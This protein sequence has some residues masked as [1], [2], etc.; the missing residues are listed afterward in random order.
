MDQWTN[1]AGMPPDEAKRYVLAHITD[2]NLLKKQIDEAKAEAATW[3]SRAA[4]A[5]AKGMAELQSQ[6]Q[7][8]LESA[9]AKIQSL[10]AEAA[11]LASDIARMKEQ[12]PGLEARV[13]SVDPDVL[14]AGLQM[15]TGEMDDPGK[16]R[17]ESDVK[18]VQADDALAALKARLGLRPDEGDAPADDVGAAGGPLAGEGPTSG[19]DS[20]KT[21]PG[22]AS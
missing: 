14:L 11:A 4:L 15:V 1:L 13:R 20:Q 12:I 19:D 10:E 5:A 7:A 16:A 18:S 22:G 2:L 9:N 17:L 6:A 3:E 21:E 8:Q